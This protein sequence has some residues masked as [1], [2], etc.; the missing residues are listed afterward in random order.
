MF[1]VA[2]DVDVHAG[3]LSK[4]IG[5]QGGFVACSRTMKDLLLSRGRPY[6]FSTALAAPSVAAASAAIDAAAQASPQP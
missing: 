1:G 6:I 3:T 5:S 2:E 4:A